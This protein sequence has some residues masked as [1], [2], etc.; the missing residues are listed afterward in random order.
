ML[1][2]VI[3]TVQVI[4]TMMDEFLTYFVI[5]VYTSHFGKDLLNSS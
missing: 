3:G 2:D 5:L 1:I 4:M